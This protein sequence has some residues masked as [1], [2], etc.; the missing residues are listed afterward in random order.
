MNQISFVV[1]R[2]PCIPKP[3]ARKALAAKSKILLRGGSFYRF[4]IDGCVS[5]LELVEYLLGTYGLSEG[6]ILDAI[7]S[8]SEVVDLE[9]GVGTKD[10]WGVSEIIEGKETITFTG[11]AFTEEELEQ[12]TK[13][14]LSSVQKL[15]ESL[16]AAMVEAGKGMTRTESWN[17]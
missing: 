9:L 5:T 10:V 4:S 6:S 8:M 1:Q 3:S 16:E 7:D 11:F 17:I 12:K 2:Y 13:L 15:K 14:F